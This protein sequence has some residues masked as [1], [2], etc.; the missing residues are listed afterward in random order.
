M[1]VDS[2]DPP[3][4]NTVGQIKL[5]CDGTKNFACNQEEVTSVSHNNDLNVQCMNIDPTDPN[6]ED[7]T[8]LL[9]KTVFGEAGKGN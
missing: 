4:G 6:K 2:T 8:Y 3:L 9:S 1:P 7:G 5:Q